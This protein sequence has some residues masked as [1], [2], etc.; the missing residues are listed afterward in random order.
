M[1]TETFSINP[2]REKKKKICLNFC[3]TF[4]L[5]CHDTNYLLLLKKNL[6]CNYS[7]EDAVI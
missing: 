1:G 3:N 4:V 5:M 2:S 7:V 6:L